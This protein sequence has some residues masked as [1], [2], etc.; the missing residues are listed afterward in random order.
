MMNRTLLLC[1]LFFV[2]TWNIEA[3]NQLNHEKKVFV[4]TDGRIFMNQLSPVYFRI[5]NSPDANAP[6]YLLKSEETPKY[7]N[8][9]YFDTEG[10]NTFHSPSAVDTVTKKVVLPKKDVVFEAYSDGSAPHSA[11]YVV[12]EKKYRTFFGKNTK[13]EF[14]AKDEISGVD[15]TYVSLNQDAYQEFSKVKD[16]LDEEKAYA[17]KYYSVDHVGNV[18]VPKSFNLTI[19]LSAPK[20]TMSIIGE[21]KG[22]VL[23]SKASI[24]LTS[25][26]SISGVYHI[27][28]IVNDGSEKVYSDPIP[29]SLF[30][31]GDTKISYFAVDNVGNKEESRVISTSTNKGNENSSYSFYIDR[32]APVLGYEIT[33]DSYRTNVLYISGRSLF[34]VNANDEKSGVDKVNYAQNSSFPNQVYSDPIPVKGDGLQSITF[35]A[36]DN[37][38]NFALPQ[39]QKVFVDRISPK[40]TMSFMGNQFHN[41]DTLFITQ[42]TKLVINVSDVGSGIKETDYELDGGSK[43]QYSAPV[44]IEKEG[45]HTVTFSAVD[46]VNNTEVKKISSFFVDSTA[47]L[48]HYNFSVKSIGEKTIR[49]E[50]YPIYPSNAM[51]Y[52][53]ATDN[54]CGGEQ[55]EYKINGKPALTAIPI[56]GLVPGN[57]EIEI[58]SWDVLKNK[59]SQILKFSIE[60]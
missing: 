18:E 43:V 38:G 15:A 48:I 51:L 32:E 7:S 21:S 54:A 8:P 4:S 42:N 25:K 40:S 12:S 55:I 28:Y 24:S 46:N 31:D 6:S 34:Q 47:P 44:R 26:D 58:I 29:L 49:G 10:K 1:L 22:K 36:V 57:Y 17:V 41:R 27:Y 56:K 23:S 19:D 50:S 5:S 2:T 33:G 16:A 14:S 3:Q 39:T 35:A 53:A 37:V 60:N 59:S 20:T 45:F 13:I 9:M 30:K 52:I 11:I